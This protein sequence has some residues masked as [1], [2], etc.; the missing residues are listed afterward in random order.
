M[1]YLGI[2]FMSN[3]A[4]FSQ[5]FLVEQ[6]T[7][8][9]WSGTTSKTRANNWSGSRI[10]I[11]LFWPWNNDKRLRITVQCYNHTAFGER[12]GSFNGSRMFTAGIYIKRFGSS[13]GWAFV[14]SLPSLGFMYKEF[15]DHV[16]ERHS[17]WC[18]L[19]PL[20][21]TLLISQS[22]P[23]NTLINSLSTKRWYSIDIDR[24]ILETLLRCL[25][26]NLLAKVKNLC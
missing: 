2:N 4:K 9:E 1:L 16:Y 20:I 14:Y 10:S 7:R 13:T 8:Q 12:Q 19:I 17:K 15:K 21:H 18:Q 25:K 5:F 6:K 22:T 3:N 23:I 26:K 24:W 11:S